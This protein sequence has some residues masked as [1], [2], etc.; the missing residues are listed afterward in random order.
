MSNLYQGFTSVAK[1]VEAVIKGEAMKDKG[2]KALVSFAFIKGELPAP[3]VMKARSDFSSLNTLKVLGAHCPET[4]RESECEALLS[5]FDGTTESGTLGNF[6]KVAREAI[7]GL[8]IQPSD[9]LTGK[10]ETRAVKPEFAD[11]WK[12]GSVAKVTLKRASVNQAKKDA[13]LSGSP[14]DSKPVGKAEPSTEQKLAPKARYAALVAE[15]AQ[16]MATAP[17]TEPT[18]REPFGKSVITALNKFDAILK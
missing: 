6:A 11:K 2:N 17:V 15:L 7:G 18:K 13:Q 16:L 1:A 5:T 3:E 10:G 12:D 9:V 4:I 14:V 8:G